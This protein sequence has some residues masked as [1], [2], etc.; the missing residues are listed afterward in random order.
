MP[1]RLFYGFF[2]RMMVTE[3]IA[4]TIISTVTVGADEDFDDVITM[5]IEHFE[6]GLYTERGFW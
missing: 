5:L 2:K 6:M 3:T 1:L 4:R